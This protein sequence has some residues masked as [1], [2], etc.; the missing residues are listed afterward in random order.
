MSILRS[1]ESP[2]V[3]IRTL[4]DRR[5]D[6]IPPSE[7]AEVMRRAISNTEHHD[8]E[9]LFRAVL[10]HYGLK[11]LTQHVITELN[12]VYSEF[13]SENETSQLA[14]RMLDTIEE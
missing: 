11:R 14:Q 6:E 4:G 1:P 3:V 13:L 2:P 9:S 7:L 12:R 8:V 5:F 10:G